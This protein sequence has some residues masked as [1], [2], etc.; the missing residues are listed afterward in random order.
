ML[1]IGLIL[2]I[3]TKSYIEKGLSDIDE[4]RV[5]AHED[6]KKKYVL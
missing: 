2:S 6:V 1:P 3:S 4:G 5:R